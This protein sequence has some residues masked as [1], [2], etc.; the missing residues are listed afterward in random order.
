MPRY[1]STIDAEGA[2]LLGS[3]QSSKDHS[4]NVL[5][6]LPTELVLNILEKVSVCDVLDLRILSKAYEKAI[7]THVF[8]HHIQNAELVG[9]L[10][11][12]EGLL[13][14]LTP[15][16][17]MD[18]VLVRAKFDRLEELLEGQAKWDPK[19][20]LFRIERSWFKALERIGGH[21]EPRHA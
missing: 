10:G 19:G 1:Q 17:C 2:A 5:R 14:Q 9:Y 4:S 13:E 15:E 8:Y 11:P 16:E 12:H 18:F 20:A 3:I 7:D 6:D 21:I